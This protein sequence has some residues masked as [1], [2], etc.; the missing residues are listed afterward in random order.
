MIVNR[1]DY[2]VVGDGQ[3]ST[4][5]CGELLES[6]SFSQNEINYVIDLLKLRRKH[7]GDGV[8][9][10]DCGANIGTHAVEWAHAMDLWGRLTAIEAQERIYYALCGNLVLNN[11]HNAVAINAAVSSERGVMR[12][13]SLS[14]CQPASF[15]S[16]SLRRE[17]APAGC[18]FDYDNNLWS[19]NKIAIDDFSFARLDFVKLDI[20][21][22]E[23][24][25]LP[26]MEKTVAAHHPVLMIE[27]LWHRDEIH[28]WLV[29]HGYIVRDLNINFVA[30]HES[31]RTLVDAQFR[32]KVIV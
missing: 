21:G 26:G 9:V 5:V 20:E 12:I 15:G 11:C 19:V 16:M 13:P 4:G 18:T 2:D 24:E 7:Y 32:V 3:Y 23:L 30:I 31:D 25:A 29:D 27:Q 28:K 8:N 14:Y 17:L 22:M 6:G 10:L 1:Y